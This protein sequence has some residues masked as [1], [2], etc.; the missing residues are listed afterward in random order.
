MANY[1]SRRSFLKSAAGASALFTLT[2]AVPDFLLHTAAA[3]E[4]TAGSSDQNGSQRHNDRVLVVI[5][6]AG[7]NDG[8]NTV[9]PYADDIYHKN[10]FAT[11]IN[12]KAVLKLDDYVG[13]HPAMTGVRKLFEQEKVAVMQGVGYPNP[14]RSHFFSMDIWHTAHR[15][16][17]QMRRMSGWVGRYLDAQQGKL[18]ND[19]PAI[20]LGAERQPLAVVGQKVRVPSVSS[21]E[22]F[23]LHVGKDERIAKIIGAA[24]QA[25]R[26]TS[27]DDD[28]LNYLQKSTVAA[29]DSS[30]QVQ[31]AARGYKTDVKYPTTAA[32]RKL[33]SVAQLMDAGMTT[34]VYYI[35]LGGFDTHANQT[36]GHSTLLKEFSDGVSAFLADLKQHGHEDRV[37]LMTFSEFGRRLKENASRGTDHGSAG[38]MFLMGNHLKSGLIGKHPSLKDL[39]KVGD[40]RFHTD[41]RQVYADILQNWLKVDSK[42]VLGGSFE[43]TRVISV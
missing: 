20:H 35:T 25:K 3:A 36:V 32:A 11:R 8:L 31:R 21:F 43:A 27:K 12:D 33:K 34:K 23:K 18:G 37:L 15:D 1:N 40:I 9:I 4:S 42:Q 22:S 14:E 39:D 10:R 16:V 29:L 28:L 38:P 19:L 6:L 7:G 30:R 5:E 26:L 41:F 13:F 24:A 2:P 17:K